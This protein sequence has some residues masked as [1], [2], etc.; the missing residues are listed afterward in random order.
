MKAE[1]NMDVNF[2]QV[3]S[4]RRNNDLRKRWLHNIKRAGELP[5]TKGFYICSTQFEPHCFKRDLQLNTS[6]DLIKSFS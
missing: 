1:G 6:F 4:E 2:Y 5:H 3:P